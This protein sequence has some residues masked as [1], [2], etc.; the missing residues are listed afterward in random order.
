MMALSPFD[1]S[2]SPPAGSGRPLLSPLR[3]GK[4]AGGMGEVSEPARLPITRPR[5]EMHPTW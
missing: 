4:G 1:L 5:T 2:L 3:G